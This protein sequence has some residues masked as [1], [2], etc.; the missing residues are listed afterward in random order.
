MTP[1]ERDRQNSM[2]ID[3]KATTFGRRLFLTSRGYLG[4]G[5]ASAEVNDEV[6][7]FSG[8]QVLYVVRKSKGDRFEFVGECYVHDLMDGEACDDESFVL[9]DI[10]LE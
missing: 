1:S 2:L 9:R 8:G 10:V 7:L 6:C 4:L 3:I 5:P